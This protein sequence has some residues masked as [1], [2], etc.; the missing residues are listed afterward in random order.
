MTP[1]PSF[2]LLEHPAFRG[3]SKSSVSTLERGCKVLRFE[4]GAQLCDPNA[5]PA[6][7]LV[8]LR[9][10]ARLIG[11]HK[12]RL[13]TVGKFG[14]GS[15]IGAASLLSGA[16]CKRDRRRGIVTVPYLMSSGVIFISTKSHSAIGVINSFGP[17]NCSSFWKFLS[18]TIMEP[19][20][21]PKVGGSRILPAVL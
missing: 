7:I 3:V 11:C 16:P 10:K 13:T 4:L 17:R 14:P 9:G 12:G 18:R 1:S 2:P 15:V 20:F 6:W 5:L 8:I 21:L 19:K